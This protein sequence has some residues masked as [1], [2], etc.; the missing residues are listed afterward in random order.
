MAAFSKA[1]VSYAPTV[2]ISTSQLMLGLVALGV[3]ALVAWRLAGTFARGIYG[4]DIWISQIINGTVQGSM[5]ALIALGYT[6]V[7]GILFMINFAHGEIFM[8]GAM[9]GYFVLTALDKSGLL[10]SSPVLAVLITFVVGMGIP[11]IVGISLERLAYRPLRRAPRLVPLISAIGASFFLQQAARLLFGIRMKVYPTVTMLS[12][13]WTIDMGGDRAV[14]VQHMGVVIIVITIILMA[15]LYALVKFT[16]LGKAMRAVAEDK[17]VAALMG[18]DVDWVIMMTFAIGS[19]LAGAAGVMWGLW[20]RQVI[21]TVGFIPGIKAFTA[22]VLGGIGNVPGAMLGGL[23]LGW[24][25]AVSPTALDISTQ[26][27]DVIS[28]GLLVIVL[29]FR[30]SGLLGEVLARKKA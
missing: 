24:V 30:P 16:K 15:G 9:S 5:Y 21:H 8:I 26:L 28:F 20:Y 25:E 27:K 4:A 19:A 12:G 6:L 1:R 23:F 18:I 3:V 17:E 22:A 13:A 14:R 11:P 2:K 29:I 7:Y 10:E